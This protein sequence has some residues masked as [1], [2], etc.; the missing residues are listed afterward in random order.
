MLD[1]VW[2]LW[3]NLNKE[4][5]IWNFYM[6]LQMELIIFLKTRIKK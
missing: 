2:G 1:N 5:F 4:E 3:Y 6:S